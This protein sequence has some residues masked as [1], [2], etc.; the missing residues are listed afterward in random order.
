MDTAGKKKVLIGAKDRD[1]GRMLADCLADAGYDAR[2]APAGEIVKAAREAALIVLEDQV[3]DQNSFSDYSD[4]R[5]IR[6]VSTAPIILFGPA[7][8]VSNRIMALNCGAD[9]YMV[10]PVNP[11]E[12]A[13]KVSAILRRAEGMRTGIGR[14]PHSERDEIRIG[15][16]AVDTA[17]FAAYRQGERIMLTPNEFK[18]LA[19]LAANEGSIVSY[20]EIARFLDIQEKNPNRSKNI[21]VVH[22]SRLR[23]KIDRSGRDEYIH[24][25]RGRGYRMQ[26]IPAD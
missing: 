18:I 3:P 15:D 5:R 11:L 26:Y 4:I 2:L 7:G 9:D 17:S 23:D 19:L 20:E 22:V 1:K 10:D 14:G 24:S 6:E 12:M 8:N 21:I 13:A 25:V 16:I